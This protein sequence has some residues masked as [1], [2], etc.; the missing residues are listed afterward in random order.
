MTSTE[1]QSDGIRRIA[2]KGEANGRR[3][4][5]VVKAMR[6]ARLN[7]MHGITGASRDKKPELLRRLKSD[8]VL[9][10]AEFF[11]L[12]KCHEI[13]TTRQ[14]KAFARLHNKY[15][16]DT[17]DSPEELEWLD[18]T[19]MQLD[20]AFFSEL[21][22][23]KLAE[24]FQRNPPSFDQSD[25][26]RF[27]VTQQSGENCRRSL[28]TLQQAGLLDAN[29]IPYGSIVLHSSGKLEQIYL[30]HINAL[31]AGLPDKMED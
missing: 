26:C 12:L 19:R 10:I 22:I 28:K 6:G 18:R 7:F 16:Q 24:N 9:Q 8:G 11:F 29:R 21:G 27:L 17:M 23:E 15:L 2:D 20:G 14:I 13:K 5:E 1:Q 3:H 25:L 4:I 31:C 30:D